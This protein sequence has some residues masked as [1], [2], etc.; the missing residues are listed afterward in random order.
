M[1]YSAAGDQLAHLARR[2]HK[3][4][5]VQHGMRND[6]KAEFLPQPPKLLNAGL[7]LVA[8]TKVVALV[9][10]LRAQGAGQYRL[11][12]VVRAAPRKLGCEGNDQRCV[13]PG[14]GQQGQTL[15]QRRNHRGTFVRAQQLERVRVECDGDS[16]HARRSRLGNQPAQ[17]GPMP[18]VHSIEVAYPDHAWSISGRHVGV[19]VEHVHRHSSTSMRNPS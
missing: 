8:E 17:N 6:V 3:V 10:A 15:G 9:H 4:A 18:A 19:S 5:A 7:R 11:G 14:F 13:Q 12:K 1:G 2:H 16:P